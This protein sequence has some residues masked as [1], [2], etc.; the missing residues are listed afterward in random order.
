MSNSEQIME[1]SNQMKQSSL[2]PE[3]KHLRQ[4]Q[5]EYKAHSDICEDYMFPKKTE[6]QVESHK[7]LKSQRFENNCNPIMKSIYSSQVPSVPGEIEVKSCPSAVEQTPRRGDVKLFG[8]NLLSH[9]SNVSK[10]PPSKNVTSES[11]ESRKG[12]CKTFSIKENDEWCLPMATMSSDKQPQTRHSCVRSEDIAASAENTKSGRVHEA[13]TDIIEHFV[14][15]TQESKQNLAKVGAGYLSQDFG[16]QNFRSW[17]GSGGHSPCINSMPVQTG[18]LPL[19]Q[20]LNLQLKGNSL[21]GT[22][23]EQPVNA[24][25]C[26]EISLNSSAIPGVHGRVIQDV[27]YPIRDP[28]TIR[29]A[30]YHPAGRRDLGSSSF[31]SLDLKLRECSIEFQK[32]NGVLDMTMASSKPGKCDTVQSMFAFPSQIRNIF[33]DTGFQMGGVMP[34]GTVSDPVNAIN[35]LDSPAE[36]ATVSV[37]YPQ[38]TRTGDLESDRGDYSS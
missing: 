13:V 14:H 15:E 11:I 3:Q 9:P 28:L 26:K 20:D 18:T 37:K 31:P 35:M 24:G 16:G 21:V 30:D 4:W 36:Q 38:F 17:E 23:I 1:L 22:S 5:Q 33:N 34:G 32:R 12:S 7:Q 8:Q 27:P 6:W 29:H 25:R 19:P 10:L 2:I